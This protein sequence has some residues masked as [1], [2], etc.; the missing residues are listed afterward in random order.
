MYER[1]NPK[2]TP[3]THA[4]ASNELAVRKSDISVPFKSNVPVLGND[5]GELLRNSCFQVL[6]TGKRM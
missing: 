2:K 1:D 3:R 5:L 6:F 4:N